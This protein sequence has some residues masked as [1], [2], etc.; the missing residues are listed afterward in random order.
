MGTMR[1][2]SMARPW[3]GWETD[4]DAGARAD[5]RERFLRQAGG[6]LDRAWRLAGLILGDRHDAED[7]TQEALVRAW[8]GLDS[9]RD[10]GGF[11]AWFDRILVNVCRDRIRDARRHPVLDISDGLAPEPAARV[12]V[13]SS[14]AR[15]DELRR[16]LARLDAD[17]RIAIV[18]RY[19]LDLSVAEVAARVGVP[20]GTVKSRLHYGLREMGVSLDAGTPEAS[21]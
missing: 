15:S 3:S 21:E 4:L 19:Y 7:A 5:T 14:V 13:E 17:R 6:E 9:L 16:G 20:A 8:R 11:Q 1:T 12:D 18:L 2:T 10:P